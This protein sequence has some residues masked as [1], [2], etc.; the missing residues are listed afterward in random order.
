MI[1]PLS[2]QNNPNGLVTQGVRGNNIVNGQ[3]VL[4][5][6]E[7]LEL[8]ITQLSNQDPL[9]PVKDTEFIAQMASFSALEQQSALNKTMTDYVNFQ[10]LN[11]AQ[12]YLGK[13]VK[14]NT[15]NGPVRGIVESVKTSGTSA[16][17]TVNGF[18][19]DSKFVESI[20][21]PK[22]STNS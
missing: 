6:D 5:Q 11:M 8:L 14:I 20:S 16:K 18:E 13:E 21:L 7:F 10:K 12:T 15:D 4:G 9:E 1:D 17:L 3:Q 19:Y 2:V 22:V